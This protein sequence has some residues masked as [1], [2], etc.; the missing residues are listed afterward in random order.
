M[1]TN[2]GEFARPPRQQFYYQPLKM[3]SDGNATKQDKIEREFESVEEYEFVTNF[4]DVA[5]NTILGTYGH[6]VIS[7]DLFNKSHDIADY[8]FHNE[9]RRTPHTDT[10]KDAKN[11]F[12]ISN[13]PVDY[14]NRDNVSNYAESRVSLQTTAP[15][16]HDKDVGKYGLEPLQDGLK[17]GQAVSQ[18]NQV[19]H[20]TALLLTVKGQ[21]YLQAGDLIT[22]NLADVNSANTENPN[23]PRFSGNYI[24][25]KIRHH[26]T[27]DQYR[28]IL[29]CA[30]DSV[31]TSYGELGDGYNGADAGFAMNIHTANK[32]ELELEEI[33]SDIGY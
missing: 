8:N 24:I 3:S 31:A 26:V 25:T 23:D 6:R 28:M 13:T 12:P 9:Y 2:Q 19:A 30:K 1:I 22:F 20:G 15:F 4:H 10:V 16:L 27:K 29:E 18:S 32:S 21:S 11:K 14:D 17:T 5:S 33:D 7:H